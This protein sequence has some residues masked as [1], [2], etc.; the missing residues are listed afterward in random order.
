MPVI[1]A[2]LREMLFDVVVYLTLTD[3]LRV[4]LWSQEEP[5]PNQTGNNFGEKKAGRADRRNQQESSQQ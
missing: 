4:Q 2:A 1:G 3:P 5:K